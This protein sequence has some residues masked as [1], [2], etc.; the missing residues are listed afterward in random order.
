MTDGTSFPAEVWYDILQPETAETLAIYKNRYYAGKAALTKNHY[1]KG[2]TYYVGTKSSSE[3]FYRRIVSAALVDAGLKPE[4]AVPYAYRSHPVRSRARQSTS[5]S[6]T[7]T[8]RRP[9][10]WVR[11]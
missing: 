8:S 2:I 5:C 6:I 10:R 1:G 9:Y 3:D 7:R 4:E 11:S